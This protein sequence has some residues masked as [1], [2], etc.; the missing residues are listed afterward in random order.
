M[1]KD[2]YKYEDEG[3]APE[4]DVFSLDDDAA[5]EKK[6]QMM[7]YILV[8]AFAVVVIALA[9]W[10]SIWL[11][12]MRMSKEAPAQPEPSGALTTAAPT[13]NYWP[14]DQFPEVP[15]YE[16]ASYDT[17]VV[18]NGKAVIE[19]PA[20]AVSGYGDYASKLADMGAKVYVSTKKLVVL[21]YEGVEIHLVSSGSTT[22][23]ELCGE[24][25]IDF[26]EADYE[27]FPLPS[28]G[29]LVSV[30]EGTGAG[31]RVLTYRDASSTSAQ[32]YCSALIKDGWKISGTLEPEYNMFAA[33]YQKGSMQIT[34]DYFQAGNDYKVRLDFI[35]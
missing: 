35:T 27:A 34:V 24:A 25:E 18:N 32:E 1:P 30:E 28:Q 23:I 19:I 4:E 9:L 3:K 8:C 17:R 21:S 6:K 15:K 14:A 29:K 11:T 16:S 5:A 2:D 7:Q 10:A 26:G 12:N 31:S 13:R 33:T 20:L 22:A